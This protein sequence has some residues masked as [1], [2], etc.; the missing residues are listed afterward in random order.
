MSGGPVSTQ[1]TQ[2][3]IHAV[4][5]GGADARLWFIDG[6]LPG[7]TVLAESVQVKPR[8]IR[9]RLVQLLTPSPLRQAPPCALEGRCGGCGW[10]H[11]RPEAQADLKAQIVSDLLRR[12][13]FHGHSA[14][15]QKGIPISRVFASPAPLG[16]RRRA[17]VHF[18]QDER[19]LQLG[20]FARGGQGVI[21]VP[22]CPVL[23]GPLSHALNKIRTV[24]DVLPARG[25]LHVI[26]DGARAIVGIAAHAEV[27]GQRIP[28]PPLIGENQALRG[29]LAGLLDDTLVG[30]VVAGA[31]G[32]LGVGQATLELDAAG[33][34]DMSVRTGPFAFA[35][36]QSAQNAA[37]V[38]HVL[39]HAEG[40]P[41]RRGLELFA[42]AG[43]FTRGLS[44]LVREL[45][46]VETD[47]RGVAGLQ[48]LEARVA[49]QGGARIVVRREP[50]AAA[51]ARAAAAG[52]R[53]ELVV[54]DP[55]RAGLGA[56]PCRDLARVS[57]GRTIYVACDP[58]TLARDLGVLTGL[59]H[60]LIDV[61][62]FDL[63][64]MTPDVEVV[65]VL[66]APAGS[67]DA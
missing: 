29:R 65:A 12:L 53:F 28:L 38:D 7:D 34:E 21:D 49:A 59:G 4:A 14:E 46:A 36:A 5:H 50:A 39:R 27:A 24:A 45:W 60:R 18:E 63:M 20:F 41:R 58:A 23:D 66:D 33:P 1:Q 22:R 26:S 64:P 57:R 6:A 54:L 35:Q 16:Y 2:V 42:G 52:D 31:R 61:A 3:T 55:P 13:P 48:H 17:R 62:V 44:R 32:S 37:L 11:V 8:M 67:Q 51:L 56:G 47:A 19:G 43:N 25:E 40:D 9:G 10:Q 15:G 30:V